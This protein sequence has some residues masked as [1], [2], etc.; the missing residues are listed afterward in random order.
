VNF[1][2]R[3]VDVNLQFA[4][5]RAHPN[6][7][8]VIINLN[9]FRIGILFQFFDEGVEDGQGFA[10]LLGGMAHVLAWDEMHG[11]G[12]GRSGNPHVNV[13]AAGAEFVDI[14]ADEAFAH[15]IGAREDECT[16]K[17]ESCFRE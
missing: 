5:V 8:V 11:H 4:L 7:L 2:V 16:A 10:S 14:D 12:D 6:V 17:S 1:L 15:G 13:G 3:G 9:E